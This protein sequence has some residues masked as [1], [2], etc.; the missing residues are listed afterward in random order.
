VSRSQAEGSLVEEVGTGGNM[1][2]GVSQFVRFHVPFWD[3]CW[4]DYLP[5]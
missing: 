3:H 1:K 2:L 4:L 5:S